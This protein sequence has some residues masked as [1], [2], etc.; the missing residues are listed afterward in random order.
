[1]PLNDNKIPLTNEVLKLKREE[2]EQQRID[3]INKFKDNKQKDLGLRDDAEGPQ[4]RLR[5]VDQYHVGNKGS[6]LHEHYS[7]VNKKEILNDSN[8]KS[9]SENETKPAKITVDD[10]VKTSLLSESSHTSLTNNRGANFPTLLEVENQ[11]RSCLDSLHGVQS[12]PNLLAG[13]LAA[14]TR[15]TGLMSRQQFAVVL[16]QFPILKL[17]SINLGVCMNYFNIKKDEKKMSYSTISSTNNSKE[18]LIDYQAFCSFISFKFPELLPANKFL[19]HQIALTPRRIQFLYSKDKSGIGYLSRKELQKYFHDIGYGHLTS[20]IITNACELFEIKEVGSVNYLNLI[21]YI[22]ENA[23]SQAFAVLQVQFYNLVAKYCNFHDND[24]DMDND[25]LRSVYNEIKSQKYKDERATGFSSAEL[26]EYLQSHEINAPVDAIVLLFTDIDSD[27]NNQVFYAD[28]IRWLRL[29]RTEYS[30]SKYLD[31]VTANVSVTEIQQKLCKYIL[32]INNINE[33]EANSSS[34]SRIVSVNDIYQ[35]FEVYDVKKSGVLFIE[36]FIDVTRRLGFLL[37]KSELTTIVNQFLWHEN[38][39][40]VNYLEFISWCMPSENRSHKSQKDFERSIT[41]GPSFSQTSELNAF[42]SSIVSS[43]KNYRSSQESEN[44]TL[45]KT[46]RKN[47][48]VPSLIRLLEK[49]IQHGIDLLQVFGRYDKS[50]KGRLHWNDFCAGL[51]DLG[52]SSTTHS[53]VID[54]AD[55]FKAT[56]GDYIL[57]RRIIS[58]LLRY[59]DDANKSDELDIV[60]IIKA[61]VINKKVSLDNLKV[62]FS[63]H[64]RYNNGKVYEEDINK[65]FAEANI[66]LKSREVNIFCDKYSMIGN[67]KNSVISYEAFLMDLEKRLKGHSSIVYKSLSDDLVSKLSKLIDGLILNGH[68]Y[69]NEFDYYDENF[70]GTISKSNFHDLLQ[71]KYHGKLTYIELT[72]IDNVYEDK[73]KDSRNISY[74]KF[75]YD[76]HPR[77]SHQLQFVSG[78]LISALTNASGRLA[79]DEL[80]YINEILDSLRLKIRRRCNEFRNVNELKKP[81]KHFARRKSNPNRVTL[82]DFEVAVKELGMKVTS[83]HT[84]VMFLA[85]SSYSNVNDDIQNHIGNRAETNIVDHSWEYSF[86]FVDFILFVCDPYFHDVIWKFRRLLSRSYISN[87]E[88]MDGL[89]SFDKSNSGIITFRQFSKLMKSLNIDLSESDLNRLALCFHSVDQGL[90]VI[91]VSAFANFI[92]GRSDSKETDNKVAKLQSTSSIAGAKSDGT[93]LLFDFYILILL[94]YD[95][96]VCSENKTWNQLKQRIEEKLDDGMTSH[97]V[98]SIFDVDNKGYWFILFTSELGT[99]VFVFR[100]TGFG[101]STAWRSGTWIDLQSL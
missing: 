31:V 99:F 37:T 57:Y 58:E 92:T 90:D 70:N 26:I 34:R 84:E 45:N 22:S 64:D 48:I 42:S 27:N 41:H 8:F 56:V 13:Y 79:A 82:K 88:V 51:G 12:P 83:E 46:V 54:L 63:N 89:L 24:T 85:I 61:E 86:H 94:I 50:G 77:F 21:E 29:Y 11:I 67:G 25:S 33:S 1:M 30:R 60:D 9:P 68:D 18:D 74:L 59:A 78:R 66:S 47:K 3:L 36:I 49:K 7:I 19:S 72:S 43:N 17:H 95:I 40:F 20:S 52:I 80:K 23:L 55:R 35:A 5:Q 53:D 91:S 4:E 39:E 14:D 96:H 15:R 10:P 62:I 100:C 73:S 76:V 98:F 81:F 65:V 44:D 16:Q 75:F 69:R 71:D 87:Q 28:F 2:F 38:S 93:F 101:C 97:E 6:A 32:V